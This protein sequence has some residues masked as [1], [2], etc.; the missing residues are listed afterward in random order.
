ME[1]PA[2]KTALKKAL[3]GIADDALALL[4]WRGDELTFNQGDVVYREGSELDRT[5]AI[6]LAG[7]LSIVQGN[8][9]IA[10]ISDPICFG[11]VGFFGTQKKRTATVRVSSHKA[12]ILRL[13]IDPEELK[14]GPLSE[15]G[16]ILKA[17]AWETV[18]QD[19]QRKL[20]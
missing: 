15:L 17:R 6:L 8:E 9:T 19:S 5:V 12:T 3:P 14:A 4:F 20:S 16:K 10:Q 2:V 11:E 1:Y 18:V 13:E 7:E